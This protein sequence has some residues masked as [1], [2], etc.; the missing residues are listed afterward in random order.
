MESFRNPVIVLGCTTAG[1]LIASDVLSTLIKNSFGQ[2]ACS[3][4]NRRAFLLG[5]VLAGT[6]PKSI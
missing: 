4:E 5:A 3:F 2:A 6:V 1:H